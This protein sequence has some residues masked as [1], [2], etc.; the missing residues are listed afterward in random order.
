[1]T[2]HDAYREEARE[3]L[4]E[5]ETSLLEL[6]QTPD[7]QELIARVFR[8]LH[9]IKGSGS[10]FGF[11]QIAAFTHGVENA[12]EMVRSGK[13]AVSEELIC[14]TLA[15]K[16]HIRQM[17]EGDAAEGGE[18]IERRLQRSGDSESQPFHSLV[19]E[20]RSQIAALETGT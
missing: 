9:T 17:L 6:E 7:D 5:L 13:L 20:L 14:L 2:D 3:L 1:M 12:F 10:M 15:A 8:A 16:D 18:D 4:T 19:T 11:D